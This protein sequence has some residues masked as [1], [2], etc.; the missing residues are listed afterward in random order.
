MNEIEPLD[1]L[2]FNREAKTYCAHVGLYMGAGLVAHLAKHVGT[3]TLWTLADF[4]ARPEYASFIGAKRPIRRA[5][6]ASKTVGS[7]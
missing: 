5:A 6:Q 7:V 3:P 1:L 4:A 2:F